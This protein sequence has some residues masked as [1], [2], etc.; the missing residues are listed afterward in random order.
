MKEKMRQLAITLLNDED[1]I[2]TDAWYQLLE[3]LEDLEI[4]DIHEQVKATDG[5]WYLPE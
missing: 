4:T 1:G 5:R 2:S 3:V